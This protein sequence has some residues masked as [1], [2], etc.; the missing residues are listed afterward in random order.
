MSFLMWREKAFLVSWD[1]CFG[2]SEVIVWGRID[3]GWRFSC[4]LKF[5]PSK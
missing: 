1:C 2:R 4:G 3:A 5:H